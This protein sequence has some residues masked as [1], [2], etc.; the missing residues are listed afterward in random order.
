MRWA[1]PYCSSMRLLHMCRQSSVQVQPSCETRSWSPPSPVLGLTFGS[2]TLLAPPRAAAML[3]HTE[4]SPRGQT[5]KGGEDAE[6]SRA[7]QGKQWTQCYTAAVLLSDWLQ[8]CINIQ[9]SSGQQSNHQTA[10]RQQDW[11][12]WLINTWKL[13]SDPW[14][15]L[16][17]LLTS[18]E[19]NLKA[20]GGP[21]T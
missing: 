1:F 21:R 10:G 9:H 13:L 17:N 20:P 6:G 18:P 11:S 8:L 3:D 5:E 4:C 15:V 7:P 14:N 2:W 12:S 16:K 19:P